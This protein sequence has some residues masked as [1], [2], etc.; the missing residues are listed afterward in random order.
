MTSD[1]KLEMTIDK[2]LN[3]TEA[4]NLSSLKK[5]FNESLEILS[6]SQTSLEQ[7]YDRIIDEGKKEAEKIEKQIIGGSDLET[8]NKQI[9]LVEE[10]IQKVFEKAIE[11]IKSTGRD[12]KYSKLLTLLL[13]ESTQALGTT[14]V[15]VYS[16]SKDKEIVKPLLSKFSGAEFSND[17]INCL[18][19]VEVK[20]KD[21]TMTF[22]NTID[23]RF[24]RMKPLIRKDIAKKFGIGN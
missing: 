6:K 15:I 22:N 11:K 21:G 18:G 10:S 24:D 12:E 20:S 8:R 3:Q 5:S 19:G 16:N 23:A 17:S 13:E 4:E 1:P 14:D 2:I 9:L 7:E